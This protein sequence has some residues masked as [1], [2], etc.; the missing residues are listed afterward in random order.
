M[1]HLGLLEEN[2]EEREKLNQALINKAHAIVKIPGFEEVLKEVCTSEFHAFIEQQ[3]ASTAYTSVVNVTNLYPSLSKNK[4][5]LLDSFYFYMNRLR[6]VLIDTIDLNSIDS[7]EWKKLIENDDSPFSYI[8][9]PPNPNG[10]NMTSH[11]DSP[12]F[13]FLGALNRQGLEVRC[14][15]KWCE[16]NT[17][18]DEVVVI[19]GALLHFMSKKKY[20]PLYHR[21]EFKKNQERITIGYLFQ[22]KM[23]HELLLPNSK[24]SITYSKFHEKRLLVM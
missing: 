13:T 17:A 10:V 16:I 1:F 23:D 11:V 20:P 5:D 15:E 9:F 2:S 12:L 8:H 24:E 7:N 4:D 14:D 3:K 18:D 21:V 6:K 19:N 22:P